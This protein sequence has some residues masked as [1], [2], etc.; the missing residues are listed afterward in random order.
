VRLFHPEAQ[1]SIFSGVPG[2]ITYPQLAGELAKQNIEMPD[3]NYHPDQGK[4]WW[5]WPKEWWKFPEFFPPSTN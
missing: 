5:K 1:R 4:S 3:Y 2:A